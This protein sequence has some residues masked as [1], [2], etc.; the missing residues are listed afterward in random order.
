MKR[1]STRVTAGLSRVELRGLDP[2]LYMRK[3]ALNFGYACRRAQTRCCPLPIIAC[4]VANT[5]TSSSPGKQPALTFLAMD[6]AIAHCTRGLSIWE[7]ASNTTSEPAPWE[8]FSRPGSKGS[9]PADLALPGPSV[10]AATLLAQLEDLG[11]GTARRGGRL[12][13]IGRRDA[14]SDQKLRRAG[15]PHELSDDVSARCD[16]RHVSQCARR[17]AR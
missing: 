16:L 9:F 2:I 12:L 1:A 4:A 5:S 8:P 13:L 7:W 17:Q 6:E 14:D 3:R 15:L 11:D 10:V